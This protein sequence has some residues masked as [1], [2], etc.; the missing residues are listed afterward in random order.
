MNNM[1]FKYFPVVNN[2]L[3]R[4][5]GVAKVTGQAHYAAEHPLKG[6]TYAVLVGSTIARGRIAGIDSRAAE[7]APGV[8]A[9]ISHLNASNPAGYNATYDP[10]KGPTGGTEL[11]IFSD[12]F[13]RFSGQPVA[14]VVADTLERAQYAASLVKVQYQKEAHETSLD[15]VQKSKEPLKGAAYNDYT[16]GEPTAIDNAAVQVDATY[17][18][19]LEVHN[20]MELHATT[21]VWDGDEKVTV[22]EKTQGVKST[23]R[24]IMRAFKLEEK[25]VQVHAD[26][27]GG[28]FGSALR[29]WP[30]AIAAVMA[31]KKVNK[32]VKLVLDRTQ[33]FYMVGYRPETIQHVKIGA[34]ADGKL[35]A[36][37]HEATSQTSNYEEFREGTV[38]MSRFMYACPNVLTRY[39]VYPLDLS[40]PTWMRG[41]GEATGAFALECALD[42]LAYKLNVDPLELRRKNYADTDPQRNVPY[43]SKFL[44]EAYD[45][46]AEKFGWKERNPAPRSMKEG[47][48]L[49]GYGTASGVFGASRGTARAIGRL[50]ADGSLVIRSAVADSG[51]GTATAMVQIASEILGISPAN[52]R[53]ELGDSSFPPGPTQGGSTTTSTLGSV[54]HAVATSIRQKLLDAV[55]DAPVFHTANVHDLKPEDVFFENGEIVLASDKS[56]KISISEAVRRSGLQA[57]EVEEES[58][59]SE[60]ARKFASY[61]FSVHFVKVLVHPATGVVRVARVVTAVDGGRIVSPKTAES[62]IIGGVVGG[63]G[64]A[65]TEEGVVDHRY[66]RWVNNNFAD[67]HVP[68]HADVPHVE[69]HF[70]N[71][72]D[73]VLNPMGSKGIGEVAMIGFAPAVA[74][75]VFHATGKRIRS[76]PITPAKL[77]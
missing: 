37:V 22:Y 58:R 16:R 33:M 29:T 14:M 73:P 61:S 44:R 57:I 41:P 20:P 60:E 52:I 64:M 35:Q 36:I 34:D 53:F 19:P 13:V 32:P 69:V 55:K 74:N 75:A 11:Q 12:P 25:N 56:K 71:K 38:N 49:V 59:G 8:M 45:I 47:E 72:P 28:G 54:V 3:D 18:I 15:A 66:G 5:D 65:L 27:V 70:V 51:P 76:L 43:S 23:Q 1:S 68:V 9:V 63:I 30:H 17:S 24:N 39:K 21:A 46:G 6:I 10:A 50:E 62:Q 4:V 67:Y 42:E 40:T 48:W 26:F 2:D 7:R 77:I 31:A